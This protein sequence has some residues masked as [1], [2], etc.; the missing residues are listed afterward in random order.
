[1]GET[2]VLAAQAHRE[3][4]AVVAVDL[5]GGQVLEGRRQPFEHCGVATE[6]EDRLALEDGRRGAEDGR[7]DEAAGDRPGEHPRGVRRDRAH[8]HEDGVRLDPVDGAVLAEADGADG[9]VV[10][11]RGDDDVG[12]ARRPRRRR[13]TPG[14]PADQWVG[15]LRRPVPDGQLVSGIEQPGGDG[16]AHRSETQNSDSHQRISMIGMIG[17]PAALSSAGAA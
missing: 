13:R 4:A 17:R 2:E 5:P 8:V 15:A 11:Q 3:P 16:A 6:Q 9:G 7:V 10:A 1:V 12:D 14:A